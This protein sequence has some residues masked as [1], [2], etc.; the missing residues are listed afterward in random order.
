MLATFFRWV[1]A[2]MCVRPVK[3]NL[4]WFHNHR[5]V[6]EGAEELPRAASLS[7]LFLKWHMPNITPPGLLAGVVVCTLKLLLIVIFS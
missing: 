3:R 1:C 5:A 7:V 2:C 6:I 4:E